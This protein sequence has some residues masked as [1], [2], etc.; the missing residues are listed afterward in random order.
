MS[1]KLTQKSKI[2]DAKNFMQVW[3]NLRKTTRIKTMK[4]FN[5]ARNC[6]ALG[7]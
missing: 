5:M 7:C 6:F 2:L 1:P 3:S 4:T